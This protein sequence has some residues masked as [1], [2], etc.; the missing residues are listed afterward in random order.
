M[1]YT[2]GIFSKFY[3]FVFDVYVDLF[4]FVHRYMYAHVEVKDQPWH[5]PSG[6]IHPLETGCCTRLELTQ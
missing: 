2:K 4:I 1:F 3:L 5:C 6:V